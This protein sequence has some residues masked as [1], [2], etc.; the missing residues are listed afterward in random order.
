MRKLKV[1][2]IDLVTKAPTKSLWARIM[3]ANFAS[4]MPQ[5]VGVW[6]EEEGHDVSFVCYTGFGNLEAELPSNLDLVFIGA[7]TQAA[8]LSYA[9]SNMFRA[10]GAVTAIG[11]PHAR[12]Y[13]QDSAKYFDYVLGFTDK[14][15]ITDVLQDCSRHRPVGRRLNAKRQPNE[16]PGVRERWK[17]IE[18]TLEKAPLAKMVPMI[19]SL[20]CPYTC[21]FCIDSEI[22]FRQLSL[23]IMKEDLRFLRTKF[24]RPRVGWM[25]PNFGIRFDECLTAIEEAV[26]QDSIDFYAE[27]SLS[28]LSEP[29][30]QRLR[31]N[32]FKVIMPGIE[33]W[34]D[35]GN[36]S[37]TGSKN[38]MEKVKLISEH[39]NMVMSYMPYLQANF[40]VGLDVDE[41]REPYELTKRFVDLSPAAYPAYSLLTAYGQAAPLNLGYQRDERLIP[42]PFHFMDTQHAMNVKPKNYS[43]PQF[44]DYLADVTKHTF[45]PRAIYNRFKAMESTGWRWM[46]VLRGLTA[47]GI[48]RVKYYTEL[49]NQL[50]TDTKFRAFFEQETT[51]IPEHYVNW[52]RKDLGPFWKW[53]P[54]GALYHDQH[55]YLKEYEN[56]DGSQPDAVLV[57]VAGSSGKAGK[58]VE[59]VNG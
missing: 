26:P 44:F 38:G 5:V 25:D 6:C 28:L 9:L 12:C 30:M 11:G 14:E 43:W 35:L 4:I 57:G 23:E 36:K 29:H 50:E 59:R 37:K 39:I 56:G 40:V 16:L 41:G 15:V 47:Q 10:S 13:P 34:F 51:E 54:E 45:T 2:I 18:K 49:K 53:L 31:R 55:A 1:G 22:P 32:G 52:V 24:K 46:N 19:G 17:Y 48:G 8:Q 21:S 33:S 7:F 42:F 3:N 58:F 27:T 20:G